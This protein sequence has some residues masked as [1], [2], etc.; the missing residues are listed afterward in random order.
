MTLW[1]YDLLPTSDGEADDERMS[2]VQHERQRRQG[3]LLLLS[4]VFVFLIGSYIVC[5]HC[6]CRRHG[7]R[8]HAYPAH[9]HHV[10]VAGYRYTQLSAPASDSVG[11]KQVKREATVLVSEMEEPFLGPPEYE[12]PSYLETAPPAYAHL[13]SAPPLSDTSEDSPRHV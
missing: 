3:D 10:R 6:R 5:K 2:R 8:S 1:Y 11:Y 13:P 4:L 12:Q 7:R 9:Q